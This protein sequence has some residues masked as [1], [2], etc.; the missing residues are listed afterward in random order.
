VV[1]SLLELGFLH[2]DPDRRPTSL[3]QWQARLARAY[4][5]ERDRE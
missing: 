4:A 1:D 5:K 2:R 3:I